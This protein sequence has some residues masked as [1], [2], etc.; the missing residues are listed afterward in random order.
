MFFPKSILQNDEKS[1]EEKTCV[2]KVA[3]CCKEQDVYILD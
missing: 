3:P 2:L 1:L